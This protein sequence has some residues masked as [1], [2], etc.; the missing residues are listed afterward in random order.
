MDQSF[1][2]SIVDLMRNPLTSIT[3][4]VCWSSRRFSLFCD[5]FS[6]QEKE[7]FMVAAH[8]TASSNYG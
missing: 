4:F 1:L 3:D 5:L 7:N 2:Q 6:S 8:R